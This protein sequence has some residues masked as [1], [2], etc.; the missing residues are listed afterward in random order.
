MG[1]LVRP[2]QTLLRM[3]GLLGRLSF[4]LAGLEPFWPRFSPLGPL[5]PCRQGRDEG[6]RRDARGPGMTQP[7]D[8]PRRILLAVTGLTP[9]IV[10]ETLYALAV[11]GSPAW[12]PT[13][14]RIVTTLRGAQEARD[15]LV[16]DEPGWF[17][18][19][20]ADYRLP[21]I[22]FG[23][24][25]IRII[26]GPDGKPLDDI[27]DERDNAAVADFITEEVR[28]LTADPNTCLHVSIAGG[29]KTMGFYVG[30]ALS[31]FGRE[32]D[33][34][35]HVLVPPPFESREDFF[36][37]L[38]G[39][40]EARVH[41][42][43]ISFVRMRD[44]LPDRLLKGGARF[45]EA[46]AEAQNALAPL[47]LLL[48]PATLTVTAGGERFTLK[49]AQFAFYWMMAERCIA[50]KSGVHWSERSLG[51]ELLGFCRALGEVSEQTETAYRNLTEQNFDPAKAHVNS[52]LKRALGA[53]RA[54]PY[55]IIALDLIVG[56]RYR[57][58]GLALLPEAVTIAAS[59]RSPPIAADRR[60]RQ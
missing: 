40:G 17:R 29:R 54:A 23:A 44:G 16:S 47:A 12:V 59:L 26:A 49:P 30:Y 43:D 31:L 36:Y 55:R 27:L 50:A 46:V 41:L 4:P 57:R 42:G 5:G 20:C 1:A 25:D 33:R 48:D 53:R 38:P 15:A 6:A 13:E 56:T 2:Q 35:S 7:A 19:L 45:S 60:G 8:Y 10:T 32:Q 39:A 21:R 52:A 34:L 24:E 14:I 11:N 28:G 58:F 9:Q 37:P 51:D 22:A 18:R 3:G